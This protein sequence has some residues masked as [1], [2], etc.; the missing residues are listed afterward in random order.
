MPTRRNLSGISLT[1][2][3]NTLYRLVKWLIGDDLTNPGPKWKIIEAGTATSRSTPVSGD[4]FS[5]S[6][7]F[8]T[9]TNGVQRWSTGALSTRDWIVLQ[10][11]HAD[12]SKRFQVFFDYVGGTSH[13][14]TFSLLPTGGFVTGS[15][16]PSL[17]TGDTERDAIDATVITAEAAYLN[18][19][20]PSNMIPEFYATFNELSVTRSS[21]TRTTIQTSSSK[22]WCVADE[23]MIFF[24][25]NNSTIS[26]TRLGYI[27][28]ID[29]ASPNDS[30]PY[31]IRTNMGNIYSQV[32]TGSPPWRRLSPIDDSTKLTSGQEC[33]MWY[34]GS[35]PISLA[36]SQDGN[37][38]GEGQ[39]TIFPL[40]I[41]FTDASHQHFV[42]FARY[43]GEV[44]VDLTPSAG[45]F[46]GTLND[47]NIAYMT[48]GTTTPAIAWLSDG[49]TFP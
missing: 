33:H 35:S 44:H 27:G 4:G 6:S 10:S 18:F 34:G 45:L 39:W 32:G 36:A 42:G 26:N 16:W 19:G 23:E 37:I 22:L 13:E 14:L 25:I 31:V 11:A 1:D 28:Q 48:E 8:G 24:L 5:L 15:S 43:I 46:Q 49:T 2:A 30:A 41:H 47:G 40:G 29:A 17:P 9:L 21:T 38:A 12:P 7:A 3:P 20:I